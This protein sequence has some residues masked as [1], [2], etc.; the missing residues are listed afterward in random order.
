MDEGLDILRGEMEAINGQLLDLLS[1]RGELALRIGLLKDRLGIGYFDP[2]READMLKRLLEGNQGPF[3]DASVAHL[4]KQIFQASADLMGTTRS[5]ALHVHRA[6][7]EPDAIID[8][9]GI[10]LGGSPKQII[11]GPC[12][13][14]S[15]EQLAS[16]ARFLQGQGIRLLRAG[17]YKPRTSPYAFQGLRA[18]GWEIL[19]GVADAFGMRTI[20]EVVDTRD[21]ENACRWVD[22][23][24]IG[25]RNMQNFELLR[26][27]GQTRKP[28]LLKRGLS[29]TLEE[30]ILAAEYI[31]LEGNRNVILCERGIRTFETSTRNTLD[32]S[33]VPI[34]KGMVPFPVVVDLSHATGRRDILVPLGR[35]VLVAGADAV[36]VETHPNPPVALSDSQQQLSPQEFSDFNAALRPFLDSGGI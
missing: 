3:S 34:L 10:L 14:E 24:Q 36:M 13:I 15:E 16:I 28:V 29:A 11:A 30:F 8:I 31:V 20:S 17:A 27:V 12:S 35:A 25:A 19:R 33:A 22:V 26:L 4:F 6:P 9:A 32:I 1:R 23:L 21:V 18:P 2:R 7:G 5:R